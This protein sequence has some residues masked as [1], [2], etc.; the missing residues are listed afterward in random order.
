MYQPDVRPLLQL[1]DENVGG[2]PTM[3][4]LFL[5]DPETEEVTE[6][7]TSQRRVQCNKVTV[8]GNKI[9]HVIPTA[10]A[11]GVEV[12]PHSV[13]CLNIYSTDLMLMSSAGGC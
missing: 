2:N 10:W 4:K 7:L 13:A 11:P 9:Y 12:T 1:T 3:M 8:K 6:I 5:V